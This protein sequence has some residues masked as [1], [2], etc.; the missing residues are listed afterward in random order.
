MNLLKLMFWN[1]GHSKHKQMYTKWLKYGI[2]IKKTL[3]KHYCFQFSCKV[4]LTF[5]VVEDYQ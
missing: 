3:L 5:V 1:E 4:N 2:Y